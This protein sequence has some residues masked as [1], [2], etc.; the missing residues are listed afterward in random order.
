MG[1]VNY[2]VEVKNVNQEQKA[3]RVVALSISPQKGIKKENVSS[4][5]FR[6]DFGI[7]HD[8]HAGTHNRQVSLLAD[9]SIDKIR[10]KLPTISPGAFAEN[11]TTKGIDLT[12]LDIGA[13]LKLGSDV[14]LSITQ[15]GKICHTRCHIYY[16]VGDC[17]MPKEGVFARVVRGGVLKPGDAIQKG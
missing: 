13:T 10:K 8:A 11:I 17:V 1:S 9:E 4:A 7:E 12:A 15:K 3:G 16:T 5:F 6:E 2:E 14:V